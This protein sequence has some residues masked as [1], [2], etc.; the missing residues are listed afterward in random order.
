MKVL[1]AVCSAIGSLLI[2]T[3]VVGLFVGMVRK[4]SVFL[5]AVK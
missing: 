2:A 4:V 5:K 3:T 1:S